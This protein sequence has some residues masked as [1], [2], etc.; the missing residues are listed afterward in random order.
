MARRMGLVLL[1]GGLIECPIGPLWD[2]EAR[3]YM[4]HKTLP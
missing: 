2:F 1:K 4:F 3:L